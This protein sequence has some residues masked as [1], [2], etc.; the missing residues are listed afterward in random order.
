VLSSQDPLRERA[1]CRCQAVL[2]PMKATGKAV[3][4]AILDAEGEA[5]R[6]GDGG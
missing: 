3:A 5:G 6:V 2:F 1:L 4:L